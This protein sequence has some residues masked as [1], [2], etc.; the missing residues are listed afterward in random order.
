MRVLTNSTL[1]KDAANTNAFAEALSANPRRSACHTAKTVSIDY[2]AA[3]LDGNVIGGSRR[4][5]DVSGDGLNNQ[6]NLVTRASD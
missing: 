2:A 3:S 1:M 6:G 4:V 5:I